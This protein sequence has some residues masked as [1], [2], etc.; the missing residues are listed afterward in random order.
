V[1]RRDVPWGSGR[2]RLVG[3]AEVIKVSRL[4]ADIAR[5]GFLQGD[6][7]EVAGE[8][9]VVIKSMEDVSVN[10]CLVIMN[11]SVVSG[12]FYVNNCRSRSTSSI[13]GGARG[14]FSPEDPLSMRITCAGRHETAKR[15]SD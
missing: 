4:M 13:G 10:D 6:E 15:P 14:V 7:V 9:A 3:G 1:V 12:H 5:T 2:V 8:R 11:G